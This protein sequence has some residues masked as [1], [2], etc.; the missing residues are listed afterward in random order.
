[1]TTTPPLADAAVLLTVWEAASTVP[2]CAVGAALLHRSGLVDEFADAL[3]LTL[4]TSAAR[5][6]GLYVEA[7]GDV[8][9]AVVTCPACGE[10]LEVALPLAPLGRTPDVPA[11]D[12]VAVPETDG[13]LVVRCPT[14][15]DMLV[16][17]TSDDPTATL[18]A[19]CVT[20]AGGH[21]VDPASLDGPRRAAVDAA[22]ERLACAAAVELR[23]ECP[24]CGD[25][26]SVDVDVPALVWQR[27]GV[28]VPVVL[29]EVAE[30]SAAFGWS[31][32]DVL[33]MSRVRRDAYLSL[34]RGHR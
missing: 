17:A 33:A 1:M 9:D 21:P 14:N 15:R 8:V 30:L 27:I 28:E 22:T 11:T 2:A 5:I 6:V 18:L 26:V 34:L 16:A 19:R 32:A 7:F 3:D 23:S 12:D 4:A 31:E 25:E 13:R 24:A 29:A 20:D 10:T